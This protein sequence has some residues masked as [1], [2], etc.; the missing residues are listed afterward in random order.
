[1][2][3]GGT[4]QDIREMTGDDNGR[5]SPYLKLMADKGLVGKEAKV[6]RG[7]RYTIAD[8]LLKLWLR[9]GNL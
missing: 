7:G 9:E 1:M 5:L 8:P 4:L 6:V 2:E 3:D